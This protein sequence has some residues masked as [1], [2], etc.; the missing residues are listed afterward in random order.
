MHNIQFG[1]ITLQFRPWKYLLHQWKVVEELGFDSIWVADHFCNYNQPEQPW[2]EGWATLTGLASVTDTARIGTLVTSISLRHPAMLARQVLT[3]DHISHGR[4]NIGIGAGAPSSEGEIV[5]DMIGIEDWGPVER[6]AHFKEYIEIIDTLLRE[7]I[8]SYSGKYYH[9]KEAAL[10][11]PPVQ[12]PRPPITVGGIRPHMLRIA[13]EYA[14][15]WNT[16]GGINLGPEE[17]FASIKNQ[18]AMV[19]KYCEEANRDP[20]TLRRSILVYGKEGSTIYDSEDNFLEF[21]DKY[22]RIGFSEFI[23]YYPWGEEQMLT[24]R[25]VAE[26]IIPDL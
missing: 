25:K 9:L 4:L 5:Y 12:K 11:P 1:V 24:F 10:Y 14:D 15:T 22:R 19:D 18:V 2:L 7:Q 17:M 6:V 21:V 3:V 16:F 26:E 23:L 8:C 20:S 13:A